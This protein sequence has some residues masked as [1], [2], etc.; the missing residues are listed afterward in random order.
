MSRGLLLALALLAPVA[1][2]ERASTADFTIELPAGW[3]A[4]SGVMG[5]PL[6]ARPARER[7]RA[8]WGRDLITVTREPAGTL[9]LPAF[10]QRKLAQLAYHAARFEK[11]EQ[12]A[13][14]L[15]GPGGGSALLS[16]VRYTEG[17]REIAALV[18]VLESRG[19]FLTAT[20]SSS[21]QHL[22][23]KRAPLLA[24][25]QSLRA[26]GASGTSASR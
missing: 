25:L 10:A 16:R 19:T 1:L 14:Q 21:V 18:L 15:P 22:E 11:L 13:L 6:M 7:D 20:A 23:A 26:S 12:R 2:A 3:E 24:A 9:D 8:G 4:Q 5:V 17:P